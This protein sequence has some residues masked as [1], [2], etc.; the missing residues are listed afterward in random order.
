M[1]LYQKCRMART[2]ISFPVKHKLWV[3]GLP[4]GIR[5]QVGLAK[6]C[7]NI[8]IQNNVKVSTKKRHLEAYEKSDSKPPNNIS[9]HIV[10]FMN[11]EVGPKFGIGSRLEINL[12]QQILLSF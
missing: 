8:I 10:E 1:H 5:N 2:E 6:S 11:G 12:I 4:N 9:A 3:F 7:E